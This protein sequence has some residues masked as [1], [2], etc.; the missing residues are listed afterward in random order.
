MTNLKSY[1]SQPKFH[2]AIDCVIFGYEDDELKLLLYPRRFEP[3]FHNWSLIGGF[4]QEDESMDMTARRVLKLTVGLEDIYLD[5]VGG[6]SNPERDPGGRVIS[7]AYYSLIRINEHDKDLSSQHGG[8]WHSLSSIPETVFDHS[9]M[10]DSALKKL[11]QKATYEL[12]GRELLPKSFT[13]TQLN[14]L[15]NAIFQR[16]FDP[17]NFRK[18]VSSLKILNKLEI[19]ETDSSKRGAYYYQ[20]KENI[21][22]DNYDRIV[23]F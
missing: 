16:T 23:K 8:K 3:S 6:F 12:I 17:G 2:L 21:N 4:V 7:M 11:Q 5:Q 13:L 18:K 10:I 15:Y 14:N 9:E 22:H 19:K 20:F 1:K